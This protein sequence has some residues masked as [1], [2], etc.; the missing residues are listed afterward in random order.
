V[1]AKSADPI[2][3]QLFPSSFLNNLIFLSFLWRQNQLIPSGCQSPVHVHCQY[4]EHK[5]HCVHSVCTQSTGFPTESIMCSRQ[6]FQLNPLCAADRVPTESIVCSRQGSNW[7]H[8]V[9]STGFPTKPSVCI[10]QG[11]QL[12]PLCVLDRVSNWTHCVYSTGFPTEPNVCV[13]Q[14][15]QID[16]SKKYTLNDSL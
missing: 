5:L 2:W 13:R 6:G 9:Q 15:F 7:I 11:F 8:C 12:N 14:G 4:K 16:L 3:L 1:K 10:R